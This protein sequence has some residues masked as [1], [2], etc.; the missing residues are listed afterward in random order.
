MKVPTLSSAALPVAL[1][2]TALLLPGCANSPT[3]RS[4]YDKAADFGH[5][6]TFNFV[7][8]P[9]TDK[10]GYSSLVTQQ[11]KSAVGAELQKRGYQMSD[12]PDLLVNFSGKLQKMQDVQSSP[13]P[14]GPYYGY[15]YYGAWP[16]YPN[17]VYTVNYTEGTL[18]VD[19]IDAS[20]NQMVWEGVGVGEVTDESLGNREAT[21]NKAVSAIF[22][23]YPFRAGQAQ[24]LKTAAK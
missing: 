23:K 15:R 11:L 24:P 7:P 16:S 5:Y 19:L 18:N 6:H 14:A 17:D 13:A 1:L 3:I 2:A 10:L 12:K 8:Q 20:R 21:I 22:A 4:D 9:S